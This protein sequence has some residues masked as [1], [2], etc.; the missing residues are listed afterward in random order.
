MLRLDDNNVYDDDD[1]VDD[2]DDRVLDRPAPQNLG[3]WKL[4]WR[5][6]QLLQVL[7]KG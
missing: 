2:D 3:P 1:D 7:P 5:P 6:H 4:L